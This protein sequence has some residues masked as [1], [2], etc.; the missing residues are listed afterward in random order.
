MKDYFS[1]PKK[2]FKQRQRN[3]RSFLYFNDLVRISSI[4][5]EN[6]KL[7]LRF[8]RL[9]LRDV[10]RRFARSAFFYFALNK[11]MNFK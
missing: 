2:A 9:K 11:Y 6:F 4:S 5:E 3:D 8:Q 7:R 10:S 1:Q